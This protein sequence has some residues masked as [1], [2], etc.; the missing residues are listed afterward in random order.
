MKN[1]R[2]ATE[3]CYGML[4]RRWRILY[5]KAQSKVFNLKYILMAC[6]VLH[7]FCIDKHDPCNPRWRL[8]V[9][10]LS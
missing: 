1:T 10:E 9:E 5:K 7:N 3:N 6:M 2:V 8:I 4:K